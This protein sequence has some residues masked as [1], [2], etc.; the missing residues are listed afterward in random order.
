MT[1]PNLLLS[2]LS[3]G[4]LSLLVMV[5]VVGGL[6]LGLAAQAQ[7]Q[8]MTIEQALDTN[9]NGYLDDPEILQAIEYWV[10]GL[11]VPGTG[12][13]TISDAKVLELIA[14]WI[15][16]EPISPPAPPP[17]IMMEK[18]CPEATGSG[19]VL[20]VPSRYRT[21]QEAIANARDGDKILVKPGTYPGGIVIDKGVVLES[22]GG[23]SLTKIVSKADQKGLVVLRATGVVIRGFSISGGKVGVGL[24]AASSFCMEQNELF[25]NLGPGLEI[26]G[27]SVELGVQARGL[28]IVNNVIRNNVGYGLSASELIRAKISN[29][30]ITDIAAKADGTAGLGIAVLG[31]QRVELKDNKLARTAGAG[32]FA[33]EVTELQI[34]GNELEGI[35][36]GPRPAPVAA[37]VVG[38]GTIGALVG[39]NSLSS[40]EIGIKVEETRSIELHGNKIAGSKVAG[41]R[42]SGSLLVRLEGEKIWDTQPEARFG[43]ELAIGIEVLSGSTATITAGTEVRHSFGYGVWVA[44]GAEVEVRESTIAATAGK[45]GLPGHGLGVKEAALELY[46]SLIEGN[47]DNGI[48][49]LAGG[50][51]MLAGNIIRNNGGFGLFLEPAG[52][53]SCPASNTFSGNGQDFSAGVPPACG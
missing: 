38:R 22:E 6:R 17:P 52:E 41:V 23:S 50:R 31:G 2:W 40:S 20:E 33:Q 46:D 53:V 21:I 47:A 51:A 42:I 35:P 48:A 7:A 5:I 32:I 14:L 9:G 25:N 8:T 28:T 10:N 13:Q 49:V 30:T 44:D 19:R 1:R 43:S 37:I 39:A 34:V 3:L 24:E 26:M 36:T 18:V 45:P 12:G 11:P 4:L 27:K 16:H 29:N 15:N